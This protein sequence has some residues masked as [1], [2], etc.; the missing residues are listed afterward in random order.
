MNPPVIL[1]VCI[2]FATL[3]L[4]LY[5]W[6]LTSSK[7]LILNMLF[8]SAGFLIAAY[9]VAMKQPTPMSFLMPFFITMLLIGRA[10]GIYWRTLV[11]GE[12]ELTVPSHLVGATAVMAI[13]G[14]I[15]AYVNL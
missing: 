12:K 4:G 10:G 7:P 5:A 13:A 9:A 3:L 11:K 15:V 2:S 1:L 6:R 14:T 8:G